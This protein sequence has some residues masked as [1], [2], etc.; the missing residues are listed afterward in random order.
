MKKLLLA[1]ALLAPATAALAHGVWIAPH[2]GELGVVYGM[3]YA[4]DPTSRKTSA[5]SRPTPLI[6]K[7]P[8]RK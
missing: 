5:S 4:D 1:A 8:R 3:G 6:S 7:R 2:Y